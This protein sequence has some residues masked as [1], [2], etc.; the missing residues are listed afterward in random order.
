MEN[1]K[2]FEKNTLFQEDERLINFLLLSLLYALS[3][4]FAA[5][6]TDFWTDIG[7]ESQ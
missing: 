7:N 4:F 3:I 2:Q 6:K 5:D 1:F